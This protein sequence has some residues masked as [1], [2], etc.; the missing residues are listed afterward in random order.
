MVRQSDPFN[1]TRGSATSLWKTHKKLESIRK[2][3]SIDRMLQ[4]LIMEEDGTFVVDKKKLCSSAD[5][6][7]EFGEIMYPT[8]T[9]RM[10]GIDDYTIYFELVGDTIFAGAYDI[11]ARKKVFRRNLISPSGDAWYTYAK[12]EFEKLAKYLKST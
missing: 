5:D 7:W 9:V 10:K 1:I 8:Y 12:D 2:K 11:R 3:F 4:N 6:M